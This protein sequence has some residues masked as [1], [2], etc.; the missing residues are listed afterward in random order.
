[1]IRQDISTKSVMFR[2]KV[3]NESGK[4]IARVIYPAIESIPQNFMYDIINITVWSI[5][6]TKRYGIDSPFGYYWFYFIRENRPPDA[7]I[8]K[9]PEVM[10]YNEI[11]EW[12]CSNMKTNGGQASFD[13]D[14]DDEWSTEAFPWFT[15]QWYQWYSRGDQ[16]K[17]DIKD[18]ETI[19]KCEDNPGNEIP[20][21]SISLVLKKFHNEP[22][23]RE[24]G[25]NFVEKVFVKAESL[26]DVGD[27]IILK[28]ADQQV[29]DKGNKITAPNRYKEPPVEEAGTGRLN[30][31]MTYRVTKCTPG[32]GG[33]YQTCCGSDGFWLFDKRPPDEPFKDICFNACKDVECK[34]EQKLNNHGVL[35]DKCVP[36]C[37]GTV[38][39]TN[40]KRVYYH[41]DHEGMLKLS[42]SDNE[43]LPN[44]GECKTCNC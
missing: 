34:I 24:F 20:V 14:E 13:P 43:E 26:G 18:P 5:N 15:P 44:D 37:T 29:S 23:S 1:M 33:S 4:Q 40:R 3:S 36:E 22:D 11:A 8:V 9:A 42:E 39:C 38:R 30:D 6:Y 21:S 12:M 2:Q 41:C 32:V 28:V 10:Y 31:V 7:D 35:V 16:L 19:V 17:L 25:S 27:V